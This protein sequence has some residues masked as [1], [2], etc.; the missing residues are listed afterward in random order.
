MTPVERSVRGLLVDPGLVG[1]DS[2]REIGVLVL[3]ALGFLQTVGNE[4][5]AAIVLVDTFVPFLL[6][7][8]AT[9]ATD[10]LS[11]AVDERTYFTLDIQGWYPL[12][13]R[14]FLPPIIYF[15]FLTDGGDAPFRRLFVLTAWASAPLLVPAAVDGALSVSGVA[16]PAVVWAVGAAWSGFLWARALA[17]LRDVSLLEACAVVATVLGGGV[18][19][20]VVFF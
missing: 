13:Y 15:A 1:R 6:W 9:V 18:L 12:V 7:F 10:A 4:A 17:S 19:T 5:A 8:G 14:S 11:G 3:L 20:L 16:T 2:D